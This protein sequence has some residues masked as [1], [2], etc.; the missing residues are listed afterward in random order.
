MILIEITAAIDAAGTLTTL[1]LSD[2]H[3]VTAPSDTP[4]NVAFKQALKEP[5]SIGV[6]A[7][8]DGKT[9]GGATK[10][11]TGEIVVINVDGQF[12]EWLDY[13]FDGRVVTI[14]YGTGGAYPA[15]FQTIFTGTLEGQ[16]E[17]NWREMVFR[18]RDKQ[19]LFSVPA[20]SNRYAGSNVLPLGFEGTP[21]DLMGKVKP[22]VFG[23]VFNVPAVPANTSKLTYQL[24][25]GALAAITAVYDSGL[26]LTFGSDFAT[27]ELLQTSTPASGSYNTCL[28][29][30][31]FQLGAVPAGLVTADA[32]Q[33]AGPS[34]RTV[35]Q[36]L[37]RLAGIALSG[38]EI[39][40]ADVTAL[41]AVSAGA[42]GIWLNDE[43]TTI[44]SAMDM[45]AA[46]IGAWYGFDELGV[47]RMGV[48]A[49]PAG[50]PLI[51]LKD[52]DTLDGIE[53]RPARDN[54]VP[55]WRVSMKYGRNWSV[56][57]SGLAGAVTA[58]RRAYLATASRT[59]VSSDSDIKKK[60]L[61][62][63]DMAADGLLVNEADASAE[64]DRQLQLHKKRRDI[65]DVPISLDKL[66]GK[67][68]SLM[69]VARLTLPRFGLSAGKLFRVVGRRP[70]LATN[71]IIF[72]VWG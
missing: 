12:D 57:T 56:Q 7:Y 20:L 53:R 34:D 50:A 26:E 52:F 32:A 71:K 23:A 42:V 69:S 22:R 63:T 31:F 9:T 35:A 3:F 19:Y 48:L 55:V 28:A 65:F 14:R 5:G 40:T 38:P 72:T 37:R 16:P 18:L 29:E 64:T 68:V 58:D 15:D 33:G 41:D 70:E 6:H 51:E 39:S 30:G 4:A 36:V 25:D 43:S 8:S 49:E 54:D 46:S 17:A 44:Q 62:A 61:L 67:T 1:Y 66:N 27:K 13:G 24:N 2:N 47:L 60:H 10:L 59:V 45:V 21:S 11:E